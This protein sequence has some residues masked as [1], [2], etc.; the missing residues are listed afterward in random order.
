MSFSSL[1]VIVILGFLIPGLIIGALGVT[2]ISKAKD[3]AKWS[4]TNGKVVVSQ[5][6]VSGSSK[7]NSYSPLIRYQYHVGESQ[8]EGQN[9]GF[10]VGFAATRR[11]AEPYLVKYPLESSVTV[12]YNPQNLGESVL[13]NGLRKKSF[14]GFAAGLGFCFVALWVSIVFWILNP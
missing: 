5:L 8:F 6:M 1:Q 3:S 2:T 12:Y 7:G 9:I 10:G 14:F 13:E 11:L 4:A